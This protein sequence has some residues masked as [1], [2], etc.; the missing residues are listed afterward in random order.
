MSSVPPGGLILVTGANGYF[1]SVTIK[2]FLERGYRVRGTVR[3]IESSAWMK[4]YFGSE[5][6]L[7]EVPDIYRPGAFDEAVKGVNGIAHTAMNMSMDPYNQ[8]IIEDTVRSYLE[9]LEAAA[10]EPSVQSIVV[11]SSLSACVLPT[12]GVPYKINAETWNEAAIEQ[13]A[14]PWD[15]K[16]NSRWHGIK[17]YAASKARGEKEAFAWVR[18]HK[19]AFSFNTVVPNVAWGIAISPENMGYRSSAA[20]MDAVVKGYPAA[21]L[22]LPSQWYVYIEDAALL[23]LGAL[24]LPGVNGER[25]FAFA[26]RYS[27][28]QILEILHRRYPDKVLLKS[29]DETAVDAMEVDNARCVEILKMMG[30]EGGFTSLEDTLVKAVDTIL[31]NQSK[32]VPKTTIDLYYESLNIESVKK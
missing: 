24:T 17:L 18:E 15:R 11:T 3:N 9:L 5:F 23:Q 30:K 29:V 26:G 32:N 14:R 28:T 22:I 2:V 19:P 13:T 8:G 20:V 1:A 12:T 4:A 10:K 6:D 16:G 27:W 25:L 21:P 7:V 31:E